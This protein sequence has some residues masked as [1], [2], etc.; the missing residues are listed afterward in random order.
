MTRAGSGFPQKFFWTI[1]AIGPVNAGRPLVSNDWVMK[2]TLWTLLALGSFLIWLLIFSA[3]PLG[4]YVTPIELPIGIGAR[5]A[6][7]TKYVPSKSGFF[8]PHKCDFRV[9]KEY[10]E[11]SKKGAKIYIYFDDQTYGQTEGLETSTPP[12]GRVF[13]LINQQSYPV[14]VRYSCGVPIIFDILKLLK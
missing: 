7:A 5:G 2:K 13:K 12:A 8:I 4:V 9:D 6:K 10:S 11:E 3:P 1:I 14:L